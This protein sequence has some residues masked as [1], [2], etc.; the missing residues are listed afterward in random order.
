[1]D[2]RYLSVPLSSLFKTLLPHRPGALSR[3]PAHPPPSPFPLQAADSRTLPGELASEKGGHPPTM[4]G[5]SEKRKGRQNREKLDFLRLVALGACGG[6]LMLRVLLGGPPLNLVASLALTKA[7]LALLLLTGLLQLLAYRLLASAAEAGADLA[8][9]GPRGRSALAEYSEDAVY[10]CAG[11]QALGLFSPW[12]WALLLVAPGYAA[13]QGG[14]KLLQY[15]FTPTAEEREAQREETSE[16]QKR[17][18]KAERR[19]GRRR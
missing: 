18:E 4:A 17:R 9:T 19:Q 15:V 8:G 7:Q 10:L 2:G 5:G 11:A 13:H 3:R 16:E 1:M 12:G 6:H 14:K